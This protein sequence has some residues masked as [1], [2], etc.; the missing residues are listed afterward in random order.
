MGKDEHFP[1]VFISIY[2]ILKCN[3]LLYSWDIAECDVKPQ[4]TNKF[5]CKR[6]G[7]IYSDTTVSSWTVRYQGIQRGDMDDVREEPVGKPH[8][9]LN[10]AL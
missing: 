10:N 7:P 4:S 1:L 8:Q 2:S 5:E 6:K 3:P 9:P